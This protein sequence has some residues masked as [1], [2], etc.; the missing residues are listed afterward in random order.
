MAAVAAFRSEDDAPALD[1]GLDAPAAVLDDVDPP[2]LKDRANNPT[3][4]T[5]STSAAAIDATLSRRRTR[6]TRRSTTFDSPMA[7]RIAASRTSVIGAG[8]GAD[9]TT[10]RARP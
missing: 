1:E 4:P 9:A 8:T 2:V 6:A 3:T 7:A 5:T 10:S